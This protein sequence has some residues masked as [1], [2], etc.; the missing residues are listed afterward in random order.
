MFLENTASLTS[1][2]PLWGSQ[3]QYAESDSE[4][5]RL[6]LWPS[7]PAWSLGFPPLWDRMVAAH[8]LT[9]PFLGPSLCPRVFLGLFAFSQPEQCWPLSPRSRGVPPVDPTALASGILLSSLRAEA[10]LLPLAALELRSGPD[11]NES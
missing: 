11:V 8:T 3:E 9:P 7:S 4:V 6:W 5:C 1:Q 10:A 2:S